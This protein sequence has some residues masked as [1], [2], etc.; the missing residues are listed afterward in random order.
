MDETDP[1]RKSEPPLERLSVDELEA[2]I[3]DLQEEIEE[4]RAQLQRKRAQK[5]AADALFG[6]EG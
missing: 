4:C 1:S 5:S 2:R 3:A 6:N